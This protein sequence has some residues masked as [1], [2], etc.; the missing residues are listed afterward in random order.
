MAMREPQRQI[1][2]NVKAINTQ[3]PSY[4]PHDSRSEVG[5]LPVKVVSVLDLIED[6][7]RLA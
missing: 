7:H 4:R 1:V 6:V 3:E 2:E 5:A